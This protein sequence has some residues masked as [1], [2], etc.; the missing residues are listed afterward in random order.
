M[1]AKRDMQTYFD[2]IAYTAKA[3]A[4]P[5]SVEP[6][7]KIRT[8]IDDGTADKCDFDAADVYFNVVLPEARNIGYPMHL[9]TNRLDPF[10]DIDAL[11][12]KLKLIKEYVLH[13]RI[14]YLKS[15]Y[16]EKQQECYKREMK[17]CEEE[18][19]KLSNV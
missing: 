6:Y 2:G 10:I 13:N 18:L 5:L 17:K 16:E 4:E 8:V 9:M 14:A 3:K 1:P 19:K 11:T 12:T 7:T 15:K